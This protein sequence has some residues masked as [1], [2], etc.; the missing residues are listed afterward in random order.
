VDLE[1]DR[2]LTVFGDVVGPEDVGGHTVELDLGA[3]E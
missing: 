2:R 1:E 3:R